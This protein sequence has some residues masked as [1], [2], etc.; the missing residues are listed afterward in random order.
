M[1]GRYAL[2]HL[3]EGQVSG[4]PSYI[5]MRTGKPPFIFMRGK[6][7]LIHIHERHVYPRSYSWGTCIPSF[8]FMRGRYTLIHLQ[9]G[10]VYPHTYSWG[11][12][13]HSFIFI[14]KDRYTSINIHEDRYTLIHIHQGKVFPHFIPS[15]VHLKTVGKCES[16]RSIM[17]KTFYW[18]NKFHF[19]LYFKT[20]RQNKL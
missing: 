12:C 10:Q 20:S 15:L 7:T 13:I 2:I 6:Y 11:T 3:Q 18:S 16:V 9:E 1:R 19:I 17:Y 4:I 14:R 5:F 8:I